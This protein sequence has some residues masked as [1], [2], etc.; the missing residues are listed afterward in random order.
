MTK[1]LP[2]FV[3]LCFVAACAKSPENIAAVEIG[4]DAYSRHS[5][6]QLKAEKLKITQDLENLSAAQK[7]AASG[8]AMGVFLLGLPLSSMSGNDKEALIAVAKGK[9]Q[10]IDRLSV[11]KHCN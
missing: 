10:A 2:L 9:I 3:L 4:S 7:N 1:V 8:D 5:C 11:A 6:T